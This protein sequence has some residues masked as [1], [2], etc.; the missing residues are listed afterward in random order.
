ML[1][2]STAERLAD[3]LGGDIL[4][5]L[6][7]TLVEEHARRIEDGETRPRV[8]GQRY[9]QRLESRDIDVAERLE[10]GQ[11]EGCAVAA[12]DSRRCKIVRMRRR[13]GR[14]GK[15]IDQRSRLLDIRVDRTASSAR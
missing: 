13:P 14:A 9:R 10:H 2:E 7:R 6:R 8:S 11:I 4:G 15:R 3:E 12:R 5:E 1:V